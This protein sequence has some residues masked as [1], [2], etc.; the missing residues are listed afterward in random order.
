MPVGREAACS[1]QWGW[2]MATAMT[3]TCFP[4]A[5]SN[6]C[7][8]A[9]NQPKLNV[10]NHNYQIIFLKFPCLLMIIRKLSVHVPQVSQ[11]RT[12]PAKHALDYLYVL[13]NPFS[14]S[15]RVCVPLGCFAHTMSGGN[16]RD[17]ETSR[18]QVS[19]MLTSGVISENLP[20]CATREPFQS[21]SS[22]AIPQRTEKNK[23]KRAGSEVTRS[24]DSVQTRA[25]ISMWYFQTVHI[26]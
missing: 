8:S 17:V 15:N 25:E 18:Q 1:L 21:K 2:V 6:F 23:M 19:A 22:K 9:I 5:L 3:Q 13:P 14:K 7:L 4:H 24:L 11:G 10:A 26:S 12:H 16:I 20:A